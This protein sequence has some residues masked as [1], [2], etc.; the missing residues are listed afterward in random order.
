[1]ATSILLLHYNNYFNRIIKKLDT[2]ADYREADSH[3]VTC[4]NINFNPGDGVNTSLLLGHG[5]NPAAIFSNGADYDYA[6]VF[7]PN[8]NDPKIKSRWFILDCDRTR[9]GQ[10]EIGLRRDVIADNYD[11]VLNSTAYVEKGLLAQNN[12]L[13]FNKEGML[14]NQIKKEEVLLK[15]N[16]QVPWLVAYISKNASGDDIRINYNPADQ[17]FIEVSAANIDQWAYSGYD[18]DNPFLGSP[19]NISYKT[20]FQSGEWGV[21]NWAGVT[22]ITGSGAAST[23]RASG[24]HNYALRTSW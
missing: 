13:I 6:V 9:G 1:M 4:D 5:T 14:L 23:A 3:S 24:T 22:T 21:Y 20:Y 18:A 16:S 2:I 17:N 11:T 10:Y 12:P 15:D 8:D 7:D 19:Y